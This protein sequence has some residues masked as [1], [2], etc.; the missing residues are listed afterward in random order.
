MKVVLDSVVVVE[1]LVVCEEVCVV[2]VLLTSDSP[3]TSGKLGK[4][5]WELYDWSK[6][7]LVEYDWCIYGKE[8]EEQ[9]ILLSVV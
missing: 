5:I 1:K 6:Y 7:R 3:K 9:S 4:Y 2:V 8:L